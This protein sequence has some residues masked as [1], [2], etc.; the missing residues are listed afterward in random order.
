MLLHQDGG[1]DHLKLFLWRPLPLTLSLRFGV[2]VSVYFWYNRGAQS[3]VI[4]KH[5]RSTAGGAGAYG[6]LR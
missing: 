4:P 6:R 2:G 3:F 5:G 1:G